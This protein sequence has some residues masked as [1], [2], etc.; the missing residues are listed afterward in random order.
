LCK[1]LTDKS[2]RRGREGERERLVSRNFVFYQSRFLLLLLL[3][4]IRSSVD[5]VLFVFSVI[6]AALNQGIT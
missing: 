5:S 6:M 2:G 4:L 3:L 1:L